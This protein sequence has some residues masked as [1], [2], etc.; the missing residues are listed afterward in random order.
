MAKD[1]GSEFLHCWIEVE[2][3]YFDCSLFQFGEQRFLWLPPTDTHYQKLGIVDI[4]TG[5][6]FFTGN[7]I[8][9]W[10]TYSVEDGCPTVELAPAF[11]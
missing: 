2:D 7:Q 3:R 1:K 9:V 4:E 6:V 11:I 10:E 8:V 5:E